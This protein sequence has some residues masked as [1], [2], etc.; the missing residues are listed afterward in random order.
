MVGAA[1][2]SGISNGIIIDI[3]GTSMDIGVIVDG[4]PRQLQAVS[5]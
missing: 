1:Y 5:N 3:G 4:R 2:L